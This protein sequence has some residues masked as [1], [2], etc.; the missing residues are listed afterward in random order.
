MKTL[1]GKWLLLSL[2]VGYLALIVYC[3]YGGKEVRI[4]SG[5]PF[6]TFSE[7]LKS[8]FVP[9]NVQFDPAPT[10]EKFGQPIESVTTYYPPVWAPPNVPVYGST[11]WYPPVTAVGPEVVVSRPTYILPPPIIV[12]RPFFSALLP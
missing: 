1:L 10:T 8:E 12:R 11:V 2:F 4:T 6:L 9:S 5:F 3:G 7:Q